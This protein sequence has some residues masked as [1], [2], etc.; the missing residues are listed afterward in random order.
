MLLAIYARW[1][2]SGDDRL[3]LF[4]SS[5]SSLMDSARVVHRGECQTCKNNAV[6][7]IVPVTYKRYTSTYRLFPSSSSLQQ[8]DAAAA[9]A[10]HT[11]T[12]YCI[13]VLLFI[14]IGFIMYAQVENRRPD[15]IQS[16]IRE[17]KRDGEKRVSSL[18]LAHYKPT[19]AEKHQ[20]KKAAAV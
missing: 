18:P 19:A 3:P 11:V 6:C 10:A 9:A 16:T 13:N 14:G 12:R 15:T 1:P 5:N 4:S 7:S 8:R 20:K 17:R 2:R